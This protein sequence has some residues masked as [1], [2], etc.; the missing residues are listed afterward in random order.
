MNTHATYCAVYVLVV[1][2]ASFES[3]VGIGGLLCGVLCEYHIYLEISCYV[4][5]LIC[6]ENVPYDVLSSTIT[7][8]ALQQMQRYNGRA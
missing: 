1:P 8:S 5:F 4:F 2:L 6:I 3:H 7:K